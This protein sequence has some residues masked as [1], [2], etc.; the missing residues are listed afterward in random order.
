MTSPVYDET[1]QIKKDGRL[2]N[3]DRRKYSKNGVTNI[4]ITNKSHRRLIIF[5]HSRERNGGRK[6]F[7][8]RLT[9][10][11]HYEARMNLAWSIYVRLND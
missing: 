5:I 11:E 8:Y 3:R 6:E 10:L 7:T 2:P 9:R 1:M 4:Q